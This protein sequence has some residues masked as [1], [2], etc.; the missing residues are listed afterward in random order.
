VFELHLT[1]W[2]S[3]ANAAVADAPPFL[4]AVPA[5]GANGDTGSAIAVDGAGNSYVTGTFRGP[6]IF[7][8]NAV[9]GAVTNSNDDV[10]VAK[11]DP[12]GNPLWIRTAGG[13][14]TDNG[15]GI[16]V[17]TAGSCYVTGN[18][19]G[20]A[21]FGS[22]NLTAVGWYDVFA[23]KYDRDGN[24][25]WVTQAGGTSYDVGSAIAVDKD[26][27]S[28][29]AGYYQNT[30]WFGANVLTNGINSDAFT[31]KLD[32]AGNWLWTRSGGGEQ[33]DVARG[34]AVDARR[35]CYATGF[36]Y[37]SNAIFAPCI[38]T[39]RGPSATSSDIFVA[40]YDAAGNL[41]WARG[42][43][44]NANDGGHGIGV[45]TLG[46][47]HVTGYFGSTNAW[48]LSTNALYPSVML[49]TAGNNDVFLARFDSV[50]DVRWASRAGGTNADIGRAVFVDAAGYSFVAG[51]FGST[52]AGFGGTNLTT[53]GSSDIFVAE[54]NPD[55]VGL[56]AK[57]AGGS[58]AD[59]GQGI[60]L[61]PDG[62][63]HVTGNFASANAAFGATSFATAGLGDIFVSRDVGRP[64]LFIA[65]G[66]AGGV[67]L[68]WR[69]N[70]TGFILER[71]TSLPPGSWANVSDPVGVFGSQY[72]VT[73]DSTGSHR[74]YRLSSP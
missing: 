12:E 48:F 51:S 31:A 30:A 40:S 24:L 47:C 62:S 63:C 68:S 55:G 11:Y 9:S 19:E 8:T 2:F 20:T 73:N 54:W 17:D 25:L 1:L 39:N 27:E 69:T 50:G 49:T 33:S 70:Y 44:G 65:P 71:A 29:V 64:H 4:W 57:R 35:N 7:G 52:S 21:R 45:D 53:A 22:T 26:Q 72:T 13:T 15:N 38:L 6:A 16:A 46:F 59:G 5:G 32:A 28:Y 37:S 18:F 23:A 14:G 67:I 3:L 10:F 34:V 61:N 42:A 36:F 66:A 74:V 60:A 41:R 58:A 56:W 43:G